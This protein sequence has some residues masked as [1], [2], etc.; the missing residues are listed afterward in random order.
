ME[1]EGVIAGY[2]AVIDPKKVGK[3]VAAFFYIE[4]PRV[5]GP[6]SPAFKVQDIGEK[7]AKLPHIQEAY[8]VVGERDYML[9]GYYNNLDEYFE[10]SKEIAKYAKTGGGILVSKVFKESLVL[11]L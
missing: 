3:T 4:G 11:D 6:T 9:K 10:L 8:T 2:H 5:E 7:L 1:K